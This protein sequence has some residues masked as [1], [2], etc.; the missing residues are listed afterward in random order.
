MQHQDDIAEETGPQ[1][2]P[3]YRQK[4]RPVGFEVIYRL[5][6][7]RLVVDTGRRVD[8]I[9]LSAITQ[10]RLTFESKTAVREVYRTTLRIAGG[11][12]L[13]LTNVDWSGLSGARTQNGAYTAFVRALVAAVAKA[14]PGVTIRCGRSHVA[15][16]LLAAIGIGTVVG[17]AA[18]SY[19]AVSQGAGTAGLL[20]L[21]VLALACWQLMPLI[22]R[23][24]PRPATADDLPADLLP[25]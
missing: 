8:T 23:N 19:Q 3:V 4:P 9:P 7:D 20:G 5:E 25:G 21:L 16:L 10:V 1:A 2:S 18:F 15:W 11:R 14:N 22:L 13:S 24:R 17:V 6:D 12:S